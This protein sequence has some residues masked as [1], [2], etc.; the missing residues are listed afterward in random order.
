MERVE[1]VFECVMCEP[2]F[3]LALA[4]QKLCEMA[5]GTVNPSYWL[6]NVYDDET[7][8]LL[9]HIWWEKGMLHTWCA[10][11]GEEDETI[12]FL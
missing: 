10:A 1:T 8:T 12:F 2:D 7:D 11:S 5:A 6:V 4:T 9:Y 3:G